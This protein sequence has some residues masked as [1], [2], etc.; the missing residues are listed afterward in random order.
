VAEGLR[1]IFQSATKWVLILAVATPILFFV[2]IGRETTWNSWDPAW[3][4]SCYRE[5]TKVVE[6][7][8]S[9]DEVVLSFWPGYVF[10]SGRQYFPGLEDHFVYRIMNKISPEE[11]ARY[12]V[13]SKDQ[14]MCAINRRTVNVLVVPSRL[15][16]YYTDL[17]PSE[18]QEFHAAVD[19][20]YSVVSKIKD[21]AVYRRRP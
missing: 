12:H 20:N 7:N 9:P 14:V 21:I 3:Q 18:I 11:R 10:E 13:I 15:I 5:V 8:T 1:V 4:L 19:A 6:A 2:E 17:S 16:E